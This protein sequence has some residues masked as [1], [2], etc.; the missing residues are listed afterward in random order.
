MSI[1]LTYCYTGIF[2]AEKYVFVI[3]YLYIPFTK[4]VSSKNCAYFE[5]QRDI[6]NIAIMLPGYL[7]QRY[8]TMYN[9]TT[10]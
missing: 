4:F 1:T 2:K 9:N 6:F 10:L 7:Y 8:Q 3:K 5:A